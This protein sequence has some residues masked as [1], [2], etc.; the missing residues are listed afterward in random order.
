LLSISWLVIVSS[1]A[2]NTTAKMA[3]KNII[4]RKCFI[5]LFF[6]SKIFL[7]NLEFNAF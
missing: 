5:S 2:E 7:K 4:E 1:Q 3:I 6:V